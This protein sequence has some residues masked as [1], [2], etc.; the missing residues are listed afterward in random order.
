MH[1]IIFIIYITTVDKENKLGDEMKTSKFYTERALMEWNDGNCTKAG[2]KRVNEDINRAYDKITD[3]IRTDV[4][5]NRVYTDPVSYE[6]ANDLYYGLPNYVHQWRNKHTELFNETKYLI[7]VLEIKQL[8]E[9]KEY[10]KI[11]FKAKLE[12]NI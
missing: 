5:K 10:I 2:F 4:L 1:C 3:D 11:K 9:L 8:A 6:H 12:K 7:N